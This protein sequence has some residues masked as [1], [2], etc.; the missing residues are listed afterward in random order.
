MNL[1]RKALRQQ[2][3]PAMKS[4]EMAQNCAV[5][6]FLRSGKS[7]RHCIKELNLLEPC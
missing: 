6:G 3:L 1:E 5:S 2:V 7:H 4:P